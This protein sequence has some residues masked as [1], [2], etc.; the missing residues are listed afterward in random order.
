MIYFDFCFYLKGDRKVKE[1]E[2]EITLDVGLMPELNPGL[3]GMWYV[4][5]QGRV[6]LKP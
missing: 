4:L 3:P 5:Y 6:I 1:K 2:R